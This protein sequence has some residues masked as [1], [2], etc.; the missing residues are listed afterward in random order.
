VVVCVAGTP[1][2]TDLG[3]RSVVNF[4]GDNARALFPFFVAF[5]FVI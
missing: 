3:N 1:K 2:F 4:I 5:G